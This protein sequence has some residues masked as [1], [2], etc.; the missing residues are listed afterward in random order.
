MYQ[1]RK[2]NTKRNERTVLQWFTKPPKHEIV[3]ARIK[4]S[5]SDHKIKEKTP[6]GTALN[7]EYGF[8]RKRI[9]C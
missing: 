2:G 6:S 7:S 8:I 5:S 1:Q 9:S 3:N 4:T